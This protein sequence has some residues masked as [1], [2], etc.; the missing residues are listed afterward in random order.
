MEAKSPSTNIQFIAQKATN[1]YA[2]ATPERKHALRS[3][4][5]SIE[6]AGSTFLN[7]L[8]GGAKS[9]NNRFGCKFDFSSVMVIGWLI[10]VCFFSILTAVAGFWRGTLAVSI[11]F[12]IAITFEIGIFLISFAFASNAIDGYLSL[13]TSMKMD[14][15]YA[16]FASGLLVFSVYMTTATTYG[17]FTFLVDVLDDFESSKFN[18][19]I[20]SMI[21]KNI[22]I[23]PAALVP[24]ATPAAVIPPVNVPR[25]DDADEI[26]FAEDGAAPSN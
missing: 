23:A 21:A 7:V 26:D 5:E 4:C 3:A 13:R 18:P 16:A 1:Y 9:I 14:S 17:I 24:N 6:H 11:F 20:G 12:L 25:D 8:K 19:W 2:S 22:G 15:I 10:C